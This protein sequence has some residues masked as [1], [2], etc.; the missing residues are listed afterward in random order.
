MIELTDPRT[1]PDPGAAPPAAARVHA[2]ADASLDA[3]AQG[4]ADA[5]DREIDAE[6]AC[7]VAAGDG[8]ALAAVL[9][10]APSVAV[11]RHVW[12]ALARCLARPVGAEAGVGV[13]LFALPVVLVT[14]RSAGT[15]GARLPGVLHDTGELAALLRSHGALG[16]SQ[17]FALA[18]ALVAAAGI[19]ARAV[20]GLVAASR[21]GSSEDTF[22]PIALPKA[23]VDVPEGEAA[24]LRF[25]VGSALATPGFDLGRHAD[26][27]AWLRPFAAALGQQLA[28][29]GASVLALPRPPQS[30][31]AALA[32]G[33]AAQRDVSAQLFASNAVR[34][35][36]ASVG[37]PAAVLSAHH[38]SD[39]PG[40]G[41]L[42]LSLSSPFEPRDA[43][44]FRCPVYPWERVVDVA[45]M[46]VELLHDCRVT[47]VRAVAGV[48][49]D[50]D[51][52][53]GGPLLFKP[54]TIPPAFPVT[55][56]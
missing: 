16:G 23:P 18:N 35:L 28:V 13:A 22:A 3:G 39:A 36:R 49:A 29:P 52:V 42:R 4:E 54:E 15:G 33:R 53:T 55:L 40:G 24:H 8:D 51:T 2:L 26:R 56:H 31:P 47:D 6:L 14:G 17:A 10:S 44:G 11:H 19:D 45:T 50:R 34:Q 48:H 25:V 37:E 21:L 38:A 46:L 27:T 9:A 1:F 30:L 32:S 20:P 41:E 5:R 12:R 7:L 43:Q